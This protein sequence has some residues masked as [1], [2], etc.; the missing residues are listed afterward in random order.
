MVDI[1]YDLE[2]GSLGPNAAIYSI[3]AVA[4]R[5]G[6]VISSFHVRISPHLGG[7]KDREKTNTGWWLDENPEELNKIEESQVE[8]KEGLQRFSQ[9]VSQ[10]DVQR[11]WQLRF[12]DFMWL[13]SAYS[14]VGGECPIHYAKVREL[15]TYM[16][17]KY[18]EFPFR[19]SA[20]HNALDDAKYQAMAWRHAIG[21]ILK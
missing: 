4:I 17:A 15:A 6:R 14:Q 8:L 21:E 16:E 11:F 20:G 19:E 7:N 9:W 10:N 2:T 5:K 1:H 18:A 3:G 12:Q 13:E